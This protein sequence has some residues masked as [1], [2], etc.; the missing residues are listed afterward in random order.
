MFAILALLV[1]SALASTL[2]ASG[3]FPP[4]NYSI[5]NTAMSPDETITF[6]PTVG[7]LYEVKVNI[8]GTVTPPMNEHTFAFLQAYVYS[9]SGTYVYRSLHGYVDTVLGHPSFTPAI[10]S[11]VHAPDGPGAQPGFISCVFQ[12]RVITST[13]WVMGMRIVSGGTSTS[14]EIERSEYTICELL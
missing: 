10:G 6:T 8:V 14:Y 1:C 2:V 13:N 4:G 9:G 11:G 3:T 5:T 12:F 7:K